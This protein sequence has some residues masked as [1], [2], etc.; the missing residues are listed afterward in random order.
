MKNN[1]LLYLIGM[2]SF[3]QCS[4]CSSF[5]YIYK[6]VDYFKIKPDFLLVQ[7]TE[8]KFVNSWVFNLNVWTVSKKKEKFADTT[9]Y[10]RDGRY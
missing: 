2:L 3:N 10:R 1:I 6:N 4:I 7:M 9:F 5:L 8:R